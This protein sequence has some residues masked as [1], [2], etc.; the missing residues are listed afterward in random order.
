MPTRITIQN[1][2]GMPSQSRVAK[3]VKPLLVMLIVAPLVISSPMPRSDVSVASVMMKGGR[4]ILV[5][6]KAWKMPMASPTS[7]RND[8]RQ[9]D[10]NAGLD[11]HGDH[12]GGETGNGTDA[13]VDA[14]R[15]DGERFA[16]REDRNHRALA[17]QVGDVAFGQEV[18]RGER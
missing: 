18:R 7:E 15:D 17:Q 16:E 13:E 14:R 10:W 5:M 9:P 8:D 11:Q 4:P 2:L 3:S 6:P 1:R 12:H